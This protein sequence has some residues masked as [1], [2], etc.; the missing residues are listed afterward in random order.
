M[1]HPGEFC[2][3]RTEEWVEL[4]DDVVARIEGKSSLGRLGPD[5][6]RHRRASSTRAGRARS[7]SSSTTSRACRSSS[8]RGL[9]IA[10]LSFMALDQAGGAPVRVAGARLALPGPGGGHREPLHAVVSRPPCSPR[11]CW[12]PKR[13]PSPPRRRSTSLASALVAFALILVGVGIAPPRDVPALARRAS[14]AHR[15]SCVLLVAGT[16]F[17]AVITG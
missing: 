14:A 6:P 16:M 4:P 13:R 5:R 2:L 3:G 1:I 15:W 12:P 11:C 17:T 8:T 7:R 10:Q 9:L